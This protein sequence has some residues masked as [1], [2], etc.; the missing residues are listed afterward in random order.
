MRQTLGWG[1]QWGWIIGGVSLGLSACGAA[2]D[3]PQE[4]TATPPLGDRP[5]VVATSGVLCDLAQQIAADSLDLTCLMDA[6]Q[7]PHVYR[8]TPSDRQAL[9]AAD[10]VLYDGYNYAPA[11]IGLV[12]SANL[13]GKTVAVYE[14][15]VPD[16]LMVEPHDHSH[17]EDDHGHAE[18]DDHGHGEEDHG[19]GEED[20]GPGEAE[21]LV[22]D[23]HIYQ[24]AAHSGAIAQVIGTELATLNPDQAPVYTERTDALVAEFQTLDDWI[25]TQ[26]E[27]VPAGDRQLV[28]THDAFRYFAD[29]YGFQVAGALSGLSTQEQPTAAR[30]TALV[31][32]VKAADVPAIFAE[33]TAN[34][35]LIQTVA[36]DAGVIVPEQVLYVAGPG[37]PGSSGDTLQTMLVS[38]T[39]VIVN[40]LGGTCDP[41]T[42]PGDPQG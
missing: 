5:T 11:L 38:N 19:H 14:V 1:K 13:S 42:A 31:E 39:C 34:P 21:A 7:D 8:P 6:G 30:L 10:L 22:P 27:T 36:R 33:S 25:R 18:A 29:A 35:Q 24:S 32:Q 23:P 16:P 15:A 2:V 26:V 9:E 20:H 41:A 12:E 4:S 28:T 17:G 40:G 37:E 3:A